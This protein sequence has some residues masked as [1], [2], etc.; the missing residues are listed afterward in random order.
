MTAVLIALSVIEIVLVVGVI[1]VYLRL[2]GQSLER[3]SVSLGKVAA[4]VRA[5]E[6]HTAGIGPSVTG[7]NGQLTRIAANLDDVASLAGRAAGPAP[8][9][10]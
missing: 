4:G 5:I 7:I 3:S 9:S 2:V 10:G 1:A 8:R 6:S